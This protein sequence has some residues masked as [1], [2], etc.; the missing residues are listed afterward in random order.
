MKASKKTYVVIARRWGESETHSYFVGTFSKKAAALIAADNERAYRGG[1]YDC[2]V[3]ESTTQSKIA[4]YR[5]DS[6]DNWWCEMPNK[7]V[8]EASPTL[9]QD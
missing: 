2:D 4:P 5:W 1:K 3:I 6:N 8:R 7:F 9:D